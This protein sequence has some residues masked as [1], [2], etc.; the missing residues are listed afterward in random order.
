MKKLIFA[1]TLSLCSISAWAIEPA[2]YFRVWQGFQ[3]PELSHLRFLNELPPFMKETVDLYGGRALNNYI[4]VIPPKNRPSYIPDELALVALSSQEA[5]QQIRS[6]PEGQRYAERHWDVFDKNRSQSAKNLIDYSNELPSAL[7]SNSAYD[8]IGKNIDWAQGANFVFIGT[9]QK[10]QS[11]V[12]FLAHL[13]THIELAK[14]VMTPKGLRGY[15]IIANENYEIAYL[16][17]ESKDAHDKVLQSPEGQVVL[18]DAGEFMDTLMYEPAEAFKAGSSVSEGVAYSTLQKD[19]GSKT[20]E[21]HVADPMEF[22]AEV[23]KSYAEGDS[24]DSSGWGGCEY[25]EAQSEPQLHIGCAGARDILVHGG[26]IFTVGFSCYF[27]FALIS[28][29][30]GEQ[31]YEV[32]NVDCN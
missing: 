6:T 31:L 14:K 11:T 5:Y 29:Q 16:N 19:A 22:A 20:S 17:W 4:V 13:K 32:L 8:M 3:K 1:I 7:T 27:D 2:G 24:N 21:N 23:S 10:S 12:Q 28:S 30:G 18:K 15:I 26:E 9:R 25:D